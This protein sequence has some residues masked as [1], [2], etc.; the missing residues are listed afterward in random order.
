[1]RNCEKINSLLGWST[2]WW[3]WSGAVKLRVHKGNWIRD[4]ISIKWCEMFR[5]GWKTRQQWTATPHSHR[6]QFYWQNFDQLLLFC[7]L[8]LAIEDWINFT[9]N[10]C[11]DLAS[12]LAFASRNEIIIGSKCRQLELCTN[13]FY[14]NSSEGVKC[15]H[16]SAWKSFQLWNFSMCSN[17]YNIF[18]S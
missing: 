3:I 18:R 14:V 12:K 5:G 6:Y 1:M 16:G 9:S 10:W 11:F 15:L 7:L 13:E 17:F 4:C 2:R 8:N